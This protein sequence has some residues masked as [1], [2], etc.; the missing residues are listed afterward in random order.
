MN[1][2]F[3]NLTQNQKLKHQKSN[4]LSRLSGQTTV[5]LL[6]IHLGKTK[7]HYTFVLSKTI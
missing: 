1:N 6:I 4:E 7:I 5:L 2:N 3:E